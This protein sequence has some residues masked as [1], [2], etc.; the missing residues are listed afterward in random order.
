MAITPEQDEFWDLVEHELKVRQP[1]T[2]RST[3]LMLRSGMIIVL[4]TATYMLLFYIL[5]PANGYFVTPLERA[6]PPLFWFI[7]GTLFIIGGAYLRFRAMGPIVER[8]K[9]QGRR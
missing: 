9:A 5:V 2:W 3:M 4:L 7:S 1:G 8:L 6:L